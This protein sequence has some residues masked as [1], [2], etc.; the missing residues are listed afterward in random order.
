MRFKAI[1]RHDV[2]VKPTFKSQRDKAEAEMKT[3]KKQKQG[4]R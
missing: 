3:K 2:M 4:E 1:S